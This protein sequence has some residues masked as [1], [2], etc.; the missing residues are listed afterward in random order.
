MQAGIPA[1][2]MPPFIP[3]GAAGSGE[4]AEKVLSGHGFPG[5][6]AA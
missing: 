1:E 2:G 5:L 3:G 6:S 4:A